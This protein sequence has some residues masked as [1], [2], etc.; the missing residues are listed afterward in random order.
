M[1]IFERWQAYDRDIV[2]RDAPPIQREECR[3][4]FYAGALACLHSVY[5]TFDGDWCN[6]EIETLDAE[7]RAMAK[8]LRIVT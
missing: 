2:P 5:D 6:E 3:R 7:L 8:D 4:A 1:T